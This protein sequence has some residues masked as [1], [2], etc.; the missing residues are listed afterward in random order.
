[1]RNALDK[2]DHSAD[3]LSLRH[4]LVRKDADLYFWKYKTKRG[5]RDSI[6]VITSTKSPE[7]KYRVSCYSEQYEYLR[8]SHTVSTHAR[9]V[10]C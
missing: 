4:I 5:N 1:M 10:F 6:V 9:T 7:I 8:S 2:T 3:I